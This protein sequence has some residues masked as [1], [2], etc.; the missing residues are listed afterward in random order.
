MTKQVSLTTQ[1]RLIISGLLLSTILIVAIAV[2]AI[3]NIQKNLNEGYQNFGQI[4]SKALAIE[5]TELVEHSSNSRNRETLKT[6][7]DTIVA[8]HSDIIFIEFRNSDGKLLYRTG[9]EQNSSLKTSNIIV[10]SPMINSSGINIGSVTV[11]LSGNIISQISSTTRASLLFVF[12]VAWIV[13]AFVILINT[14]LITR[15]LRI[16]HNGVQKISTGE[17]GYTI[18][19][20]DVSAEVKEL[21]NA[22]NQMSNRLHIYE[23]QNIEQLTLERNKLEAVLMSIANGVVVCDN[24]DNVVLINNHAHKLLELDDEQILNIKIQDYVDTEGNFCFKDKIEEFKD[25]PLEVM[26]NKPL[27]FNIQVDKRVIKSIISPMFTR[28]KDYVGY[29]IVLI[30]MTKEAEMDAMRS[31]FISNVSHELRTPVTVLRSYIDT[32]YNYGNEFDYDT[33]KEFIGTINQEII[34][35]QGMVNDILDFS[36]MEANAQMEKSLNSVYEVVD[37]C[38]SQVQALT[39]ERNLKITVTKDDGIPE[40]LFNYDGIER[41]LTNL[42]SNAIKYSPDNGEIKVNLTKIDNNA[43]IT[44]TDQGCG[45]APEFQKKIFDRFYRVENNIH[46]VKG[47]GLGLHLV[48][49]TIEKYHNGKVFVNSAVG[50]GSTFGIILPIKTIETANI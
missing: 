26:E 13:F 31:T 50:Q 6:H 3:F 40:F 36:R 43:E 4:V 19:D 38:V 28:N 49:Q 24:N 44:V 32:L 1:N 39:K 14:Y 41:A 34:R 18:K 5:C 12:S 29:I 2:F 27:E 15:E 45:I 16:L 47:T 23:E 21:F 37:T 20:K 33:Q 8:S 7:A 30:D 9:A 11:G 42:L 48:K 17:F 25:T 35:L 10:S 46:T 22:F